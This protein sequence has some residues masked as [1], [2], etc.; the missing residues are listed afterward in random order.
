MISRR[1]GRRGR[2]DIVER[3]V[4][5]HDLL[6]KKGITLDLK[7]V[8]GQKKESEDK[9]EGALEIR[10]VVYSFGFDLSFKNCLEKRCREFQ[11][12][13]TFA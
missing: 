7:K 4:V 13:I 3:E 11:R 5:G 6:M 12:Y 1:C 8:T 10:F 2:V 9:F